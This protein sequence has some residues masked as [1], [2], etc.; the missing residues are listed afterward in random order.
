MVGLEFT[1]VACRSL[2]LAIRAEKNMSSSILL[3]R[4][5][6]GKLQGPVLPITYSSILGSAGDIPI[7][8]VIISTT[9]VHKLQRIHLCQQA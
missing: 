5:I 8:G 9:L 1:Q 7:T 2:I 4:G 6:A 3:Y